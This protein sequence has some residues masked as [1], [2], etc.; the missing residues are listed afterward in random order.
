VFAIATLLLIVALSLVVVRVATVILTASGMSREAARFQARSAFT[1]SG[2]TTSESEQVVD[3]PLRRRVI[4]TLMLLGSA[5]V[6]AAASTAILGFRSAGFGHT[7][8][9]VLELAVGLFALVW[10]SRSPRVDRTLTAAIRR[11]L[12]RWTGLPTRDLGSLLDLAGDHA[13]SEL[14]VRE[15]DWIAGR[16]LGELEL[17]E[18]GVVVLGITRADG[19]YLDAPTGATEVVPGD[20][21]VVYGR[22]DLLC[23]LDDRPAGADGDRAHDAAIARRTRRI[24]LPDAGADRAPLDRRDAS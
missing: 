1:G 13:V 11:G 8:W 3:H 14:A 7:W 24:A 22:T 17:R 19:R 20:V 4:S 23:E 21:L 6:V 12:G 2:F 15:D 5:G 16:Q 10:L 9:R 18:E